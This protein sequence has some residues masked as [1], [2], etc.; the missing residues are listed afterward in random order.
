MKR[1]LWTLVLGGMVMT[2]GLL[3][4]QDAQKKLT[5][6]EA[7]A[8]IQDYKAKTQ[9]VEAELQDLRAQVEKLRSEVNE[10]KSCVENTQKEID[11]LKAEIAKYPSEYTVQP[12]DYLRKIAGMRYIYNNP[13]AWPRIFR[14]NRDKIKDPNLIYPGWVLAIPHGKVTEFDVIP[15][16]YLWKI[17]GFSWIY[18]DPY[19]WTKIYEANRDKI[20]DPDLIYPGWKLRIPRD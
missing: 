11:D 19:K 12:G 9:Q 8:M 2:P 10:Y 18:G 6:E 7:Q 3:R 16:D 14:A 13:K 1:M 20:K 15:G 4:A 5:E 17:A